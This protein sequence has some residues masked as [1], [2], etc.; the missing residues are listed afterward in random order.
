MSSEWVELCVRRGVAGW[1]GSLGRGFFSEHGVEEI[2]KNVNWK[3]PWDYPV[4]WEK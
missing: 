1:R 3:I 4:G 2:R